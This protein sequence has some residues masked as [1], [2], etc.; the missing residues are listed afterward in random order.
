MDLNKISDLKSIDIQ[1]LVS[2]L[3]QKRNSLLIGVVIIL[4]LIVAVA[5]YSNFNNQ[6]KKYEQQ[7]SLA[8]EKISKVTNLNMAIHNHEEFLKTLPKKLDQENLLSVLADW[9]TQFNVEVRSAS[10]LKNKE[11]KLWDQGG[12]ILQLQAKDFKDIMRFLHAIEKSEYAIRV[13]SWQI[14]STSGPK[15]SGI[16]ADVNLTTIILKE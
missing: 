11:E 14:S 15:S 8:N 5:L 3:W 12:V 6:K 7:I 4:G 10:P 9:A 2:L 1:E 13:D 16:L